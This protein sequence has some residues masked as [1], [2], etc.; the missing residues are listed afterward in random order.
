M[1]VWTDGRNADERFADGLTDG[2][3][4]GGTDGRTERTDG[5]TD[6]Q[7]DGWMLRGCPPPNS[8]FLANYL[9]PNCMFQGGVIV[10]ID[11]DE[12]C[13]RC[14]YRYKLLFFAGVKGTPK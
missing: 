14:S 6:G 5:Q 2:L 10:D 13:Y 4:D 11:A 7:R 1:D 3:T 9:S 8:S 12:K